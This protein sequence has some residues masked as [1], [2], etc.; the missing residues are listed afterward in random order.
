MLIQISE[1]AERNGS[2]LNLRKRSSRCGIPVVVRGT[3]FNPYLRPSE[4]TLEVVREVRYATAVSSQHERIS[5][6]Q[7]ISVRGG[8]DYRLA[9]T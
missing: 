1:S 3:E 2:L 8:S 4:L 7:S 5:S 6:K 9:Y